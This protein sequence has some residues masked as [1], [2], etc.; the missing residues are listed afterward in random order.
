MFLVK[1]EKLPESMQNE[2][3]KK[4]YEILEKKKVSL[5]FKRIFDI[6]LALIVLV[7][8]SPIMLILAIA[9][10][11]DSKGPVFYRQER[12]TTNGKIFRIFKF[13]TMVQNA[14]KIG[15]LVTVGEDKRITRVGKVIRK[16]R[17]DEFPQLLNIIAGDMS[18]V[19]TRPEVK[20]YVDKYSD[21]MKATL[22]MPAGVTSIASINFKD[23]DEILNRY[24]QET[25]EKVAVG[26]ASGDNNSQLNSEID[27]KAIID[28]AYVNEVLPE[29]MKYNLEYIEK[30]SVLNDLKICVN[31]V[32]GVLK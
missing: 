20:K 26:V 16:F 13:R 15:S 19:G 25:R 5:V 23:E 11:I 22:L 21:N 18:F 4:Y 30:F 3:V 1:Y 9:I 29:K 14:D 10:K 2:E 12:I 28:E 32:I 17:L 8:L 27:E 6:I 24:V 7:I 31:T